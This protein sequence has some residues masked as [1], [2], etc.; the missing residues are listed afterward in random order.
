MLPL[1][2]ER[3]FTEWKRDRMKV[4]QRPWLVLVGLL[5]AA[6]LAGCG[7]TAGTGAAGDTVPTSTVST[8]SK[9]PVQAYFVNVAHVKDNLARSIVIDAR[10]AKDYAAGHIPG[11]INVTW[12]LFA[13]VDSG[14]AGDAGWG[15]LKS[16]DEIA[17]ILGQ[18]GIDTRKQIVVYTAPGGWGED[19]RIVWMLR[20]A[21]LQNS[22]MLDGG[23]TAW[24][25]AGNETA[26]EPTVLPPTKVAVKP[27]DE[28]L[29]ATKSEVAA[30][31]HALK[32]IDAR[33]A[34]EYAGSTDLG[35]AR[36]GHL[37]GAVNVPFESMF[38]DD[39]TL[40]TAAELTSLFKDAGVTSSDD[41]VV[42]C[43]K[44]IRS[45]SMTLVLRGL[46]YAKARNYDGSYYEWAGDK[47]LKV[48]K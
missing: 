32:I 18:L 23:Y 17:S 9:T 15:T 34:K 24:T 29:T 2:I 1:G 48:E 25:S 16:A 21:G 40:K 12:Q 20:M 31:L 44:G 8:T 5:A 30:G 3:P 41:I 28:S 10:P 39:G 38:K 42:Y 45:A 26:T 4:R 46:G 7:P 47:N 35:E 11:A 22:M 14:K 6:S 36:G 27:F 19:G 13:K 37:P 33:T 43:T